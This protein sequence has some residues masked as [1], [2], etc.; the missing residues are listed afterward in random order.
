[1]STQ[2]IYEDGTYLANHP[3]WDD[4]GSP[5]KANHVLTLLR[6]NQVRARTIC[7]IGCGA[8]GVLTHLADH[9]T[10]PEVEYVGFENS[11]QAFEMCRAHE[12]RNMA[13]RNTD[14]FD[15]PAAQYDLVMALDVIEH[16]EDVFAFLRTMRGLGENKIFH[17]P[18]DLCVPS[19]LRPSVTLQNRTATG[20]VHLFSKETALATLTETG[21]EIVDFFYTRSSI[22]LPTTSLTT[23]MLRG[24]RRLLAALGQDFAARMLGGFSL[25]VLAR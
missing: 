10:G 19:V 17:I 24:P 4:F 21:Y 9:M 16:V 11:P 1:M 12:R 25:M 20:H 5:W 15:D 18:L 7:D 3:T 22:E 2:Q 6:R 13:F 8:G 14:A 23:R